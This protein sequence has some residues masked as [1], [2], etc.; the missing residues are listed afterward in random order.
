MSLIY[1][2]LVIC[3]VGK[4]FILPGT[5][6]H[7]HYTNLNYSICFPMTLWIYG[8]LGSLQRESL[9]LYVEFCVMCL[10][11]F[12]FLQREPFIFIR[13]SKGCIVQQKLRSPVLVTFFFPSIGKFQRG[14]LVSLSLSNSHFHFLNSSHVVSGGFSSSFIQQLLS[15]HLLYQASYQL[16][17]AG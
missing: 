14:S 8:S 15:E 12:F 6:S 2:F 4:V 13:C 11:I 9:K 10:G 7:S 17:S 1:S 3:E 16:P 5:N